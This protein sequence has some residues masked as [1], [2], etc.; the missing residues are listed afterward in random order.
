MHSVSDSA[1]VVEL[2]ARSAKPHKTRDDGPG[3]A[4]LSFAQQRLWLFEQ[5]IPGTAAYNMAAGLRLTGGLNLQALSDSIVEIVRR[6]EILRTVIE[7]RNG[8]PVQAVDPSATVRVEVI[9]LSSSAEPEQRALQYAVEETETPLDL[10]HPP[11]I[12]CR[13]LTLSGEQHVLL[14]TT[15]HMAADFWSTGIMIRELTALYP[16][17]SNGERSPLPE[18]P[19]QYGDYSRWQRQSADR[20][21]LDKQIQYWEKQLEGDM[22]VV[23]L[24]AD[25][26]RPAQQ[27]FRGAARTLA[28]PAS[29]RARLQELSHAEGATLFMT[30][31]ASFQTLLHRYTG[32]EDVAVGGPMA[33]RSR[34][35]FEAL[36]GFFVNTIIFRT[37]FS[38]N[39]TFRELLARVRKMAI[40][41][42]ANQDAPFDKVVE[43]LQPERD[44]IRNPLY[45]TIFSY[46]VSSGD[47]LEFPG[48][49]I[50]SFGPPARVAKADLT[51]FV[52]DSGAELALLAEYNTDLFDDATMQ[53]ML[54][55]WERLLHTITANPGGKVNELDMTPEAERE[56]IAHQ[57]NRASEAH[58][59]TQ[60]AHQWFE[61]Q[62][63]ANPEACALATGQTRLSYGDL[64]ARSNQLARYLQDL[65]VG[66][67]TRVA[68][69]L[70]RGVELVVALLGIVKAGGAY[71]AL[72]PECPPQRLH[73]ILEDVQAPVVL[74]RDGLKNKLSATWSRI[75]CLDS[76]ATRIAA[77]GRPN[78]VS[79]VQAE[80]LAYIIYTSGTTGAPKGVMLTH[81]GLAN[82]VRRQIPF[83]ELGPGVR[84][85]QLA[86]I[87]FDAA[88]SEIWTALASGAELH[89]PASGDVQPGEPLASYLVRN[90]INV[91]T[92]TP[93]VLS[94]MPAESRFPELRTLVVAGESCPAELAEKWRS[95]RKFI[96]AYGPTE[97]SVCAAM[98]EVGDAGKPAIGAPIGNV[99]IYVLDG[100]GEPAPIGVAGELCVG[101]AGV[102]RGY[103][104]RPGL[105]AEYFVPDPY[106]QPGR[107]LYRT[108]DVG[109]WRANGAL[110]FLGRMDDQ[111]KIHGCRVEPA[112]I[113]ALLQQHS[114]VRQAA[115]VL[116]EDD[117]GQKRLVAYIVA[118]SVERDQELRGMLEQRLPSYMMPSAFVRLDRLPV[119][120]HGKLDR[121]ALPAP[122]A[123]RGQ[124]V[125]YVAPRT[126][127][128]ALL[129]RIWRQVL[130]AER[131]GIEDNF[132]EL[133]GDSILCIQ[134]A[135]QAREFGVD[136]GVQQ[137]FEHL[138]I[139]ELAEHVTA[140][141]AIEDE[142][143]AGTAPLTPIQEWFFA[144]EWAEPWHYNQS[145]MLRVPE[146]VSADQVE[147]ALA[148]LA[149]R[150]DALRLRFARQA[151]GSWEQ[152]Y[153]AAEPIRLERI[154]A[155]EPE[156]FEREATRLQRSL[157]LE[158][159]PLMRAGWFELG[160]GQRRLL[161]VIHHLVVD[162]VSWRILLEDLQA[163][164]GPDAAL[165]ARSSS[166]GRWAKAL[167]EYAEARDW[168]DELSWWEQ[169]GEADPLPRDI[170]GGEN[171]L[172]SAAWVHTEL[173]EEDTR[174]LLQET[175]RVYR[176][177][178]QDALMTALLRSVGRW[179][180]NAELLLDVEGHGREEVLEGI[181]VSRTVG[182]FSTMYPVRIH[183]SGAGIGEDLK[184]VKE[185]LRRTPGRGFS[186]GVLRWLLRRL[187]SAAPAEVLFNY[188]G[189]F[190]QVLSGGAWEGAAESRGAERSRQGRRTHVLS[191]DSHVS[192]GRLR[193]SWEYSRVIHNEQ[194]IRAVAQDC[195]E[196][197]RALIAHCRN[198]EAG[199]TPSDFPL[200]GL[201]KRDLERLTSRLQKRKER[202]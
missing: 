187:G 59:T 39:P 24:P 82:L 144:Q 90:D 178:I 27:S 96:N 133:G 38:G 164:C 26:P 118:D 52:M 60:F 176:T 198:A 160:A 83:F 11:L 135:A 48:L 70:E 23:E 103:L 21:V 12:R 179:S 74:T 132:F 66:P 177:Q 110:E 45:R 191:V 121:K 72:D 184:A 41:A 67:E 127:L 197:L 89:L 34:P 112:E 131:V 188:L 158:H 77:A 91:I 76:E 6:H 137:M 183:R 87:S 55:H 51:A 117:P 28:L 79:E 111:V 68:V 182:W 64:N 124:G 113:E 186:Y 163:L 116:R 85:L 145:V 185:Q 159:G 92:I 95:G 43:R 20:G 61:R 25:R 194:T 36:I 75:I 189:Q 148:E 196:E 19:L 62:A 101:G 58:A 84:A 33:G 54:S 128:Q 140:S 173:S 63:D 88:V 71:L 134:I 130:Q 122:T 155:A 37:D 161:L 94:L 201:A 141:V 169:V 156:E 108:G 190:D 4:P 3:L 175:P 7:V 193:M 152:A 104:A 165:P 146:Q 78:A 14:I 81:A 151:D 80:N 126:E 195:I 109:R 114:G 69:F 162:G 174:A 119:T 2:K 86:A 192:G 50:E 102:A 57:F 18:L 199:Y 99:Q 202:V 105:T 13:I 171:T 56:Q 8:E 1:G 139:A 97:V 115:V 168:R 120:A 46:Q 129:C 65:G 106:G 93:T 149:A 17:F 42:Y 32:F 30:L 200:A 180:G 154:E 9:D 35:E 31:L 107:R 170:S 40:E 147:A 5:L 172:D 157:D 98:C 22:P 166:Y 143:G 153:A 49:R 181:D 138:T 136:I 29:L 125:G 10:S 16:A 44:L 167:R 150:H 73:S 100:R 47:V 123:E 53:R 142:S 15:H